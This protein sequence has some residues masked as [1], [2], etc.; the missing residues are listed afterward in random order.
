LVKREIMLLA[1]CALFIA[2]VPFTS[3]HFNTSSQSDVTSILKSAY[4]QTPGPGDPGNIGG[5]PGDPSD[6]GNLGGPGGSNDTANPGGLGDPSSSDP[7]AGD[8]ST[9]LSNPSD[10][11]SGIGNNANVMTSNDTS[12]GLDASMPT[13]PSDLGNT[14]GNTTSTQTVPEFPIAMLVM[15]IAISSVVVFY[16]IKSFKI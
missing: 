15:M 5:G 8:N 13:V 9:S 12:S 4:G 1:L 14:A 2:Y 6:P 16:R 10:I 3:Y 11:S 7:S